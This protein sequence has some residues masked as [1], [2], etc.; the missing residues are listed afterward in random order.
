MT[1]FNLKLNI[2]ELILILHKNERIYSYRELTCTIILFIYMLSLKLIPAWRT[3]ISDSNWISRLRE[4]GCFSFFQGQSYQMG[5]T[6]SGRYLCSASWHACA[7]QTYNMCVYKPVMWQ[8]QILA[9]CHLWFICCR[10][11]YTLWF[12][13]FPH[14][15][16]YLISSKKYMSLYQIYENISRQFPFIQDVWWIGQ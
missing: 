15:V 4:K 7:L 10:G 1:S 3:G 6:S 12:L 11:Y 5:L 14:L 13:N 2:L 8:Y 9:F 16:S